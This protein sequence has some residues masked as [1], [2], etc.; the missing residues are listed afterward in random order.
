MI[1][2]LVMLLSVTAT[3]PSTGPGARVEDAAVRLREALRSEDRAAARAMLVPPASMD[4]KLP[5]AYLDLLFAT[6]RLRQAIETA[7]PHDRA[8]ATAPTTTSSP[9]L[10]APLSLDVRVVRQ[11][12][13]SADVELAPDAPPA[14]F[15]LTDA[16][17]RLDLSA[18][19]PDGDD[20]Q[21]QWAVVVGLT[22]VINELRGEIL[23]ER[24]V[25]LV[26]VR[27]VMAMR[28][29]DL[30]ANLSQRRPATAPA[31]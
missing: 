18:V 8:P 16:G 3:A 30:L 13:S 10:A 7:F 1:T 25:S 11:D 5:D 4:A 27:A 26:D 31:R 12:A 21:R 19:F 20:A 23:A 6:E 2:A 15:V 29:S 28:T 14:R 22:A 17:W 24:Y 9:A